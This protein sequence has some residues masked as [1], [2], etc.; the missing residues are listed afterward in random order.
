MI[1]LKIAAFLADK[2][3]EASGPRRRGALVFKYLLLAACAL[4]LTT[5]PASAREAE[6]RWGDLPY[7]EDSQVVGTLEPY[8]S[9]VMDSTTEWHVLASRMADRVK[10]ALSWRGDIIAKPIFV[11]PTSARPFAQGMTQMLN[12]ELVSRGLQ[13]TLNR[14]PDTLLL[15]FNSFVVPPADKDVDSSYRE[16]LVVM[17]LWYGNRQVLHTTSSYRV[18]EDELAN[19]VHPG[20]T[21]FVP[22]HFAERNIRLVGNK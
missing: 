2:P 3:K 7:P 13:V 1:K 8:S 16:L 19:Y 18:R 22:P 5:G 21:G 14:T 17:S 4:C 15:E 10:A 12:S 6:E 11:Q 20:E 9:P